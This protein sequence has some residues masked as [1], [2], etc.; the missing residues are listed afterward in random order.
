MTDTILP[1]HN[2][3][4]EEAVIGSVLIDAAYYP[5]CNLKAEDFYIV[6]H[7]YIWEAFAQL[8]SRSQDVDLLTVTKELDRLE[9]LN[10]IGGPA[11]L[12]RLVTLTPTAFNAASYAALV[13]EQ[14]IRR[15]GIHAA[16]QVAKL[17]YDPEA[18]VI[19]SLSK[20]AALLDGIIPANGQNTDAFDAANEWYSELEERVTSGRKLIGLTTGYSK[21]DEKTAGIKRQELTILAALPSMGKSSLAFQMAYRQAKRDLRVGIFSHEMTRSDVIERMALAALNLNGQKLGAADL[22]MLARMR[23]EIALLPIMVNAESGLSVAEMGKH[24]RDM[25]RSMGGLDIIYVDHLGYINHLG[26]KHDNLATRIGLSTK[27]L[28]RIGKQLNCAVVAL[29]QLNRDKNRTADKAPTLTDLRDSGHIE[30]DARMVL[31]IHRPDYFSDPDTIDL[32]AEQEAHV[33]VLKNHRGPRNVSAL[34]RFI[35]SS[36]QFSETK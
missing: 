19:E 9:R 6:K 34:L 27:G 2:L 22:P 21:L 23:D 1:P 25:L 20:G 5:D 15:S 12:T 31:A 16:S 14:A 36:A 17:M 26:E 13:R 32:D 28:A 30:A 18:E 11:Y 4:A 24:S 3:E 29:C 35:E 33:V 8:I 10:E 7:R